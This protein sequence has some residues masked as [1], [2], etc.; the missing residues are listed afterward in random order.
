MEELVRR[1]FD[2]LLECEPKESILSSIDL[3]VITHYFPDYEAK[4]AI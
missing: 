2:F 4:I 1:S 3:R